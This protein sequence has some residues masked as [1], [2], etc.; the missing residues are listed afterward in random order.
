MSAQIDYV[1]VPSEYVDDIN[2]LNGEYTYI[3]KDFCKVI[4]AE[5]GYDLDYEDGVE[6]DPDLIEEDNVATQSYTID[7]DS[8]NREYV[9]KK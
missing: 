1:I 5:Y 3:K 7:G 8:D 4:D 2:E 9:K 6:D